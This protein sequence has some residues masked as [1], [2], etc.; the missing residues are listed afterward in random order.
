MA[1]IILLEGQHGI[2]LTR[3]PLA[4]SWD[5]VAY[6][7]LRASPPGAALEL[8]MSQQDDFH[9]FTMLYQLEAIR[10]RHP[11]VNGY[12]GWK[13]LLQEW[14][15]GP[16]SPL[17]DSGQTPD[18]LR[19]LRAIGVRA[20]LLHDATFPSAAEAERLANAVR[21]QRDQIVEEHRFGDTWAWRLRDADEGRRNA[22][23]ARI[24]PSG[25]DAFDQRSRAEFLVDGDADTR[26][27]SGR[28]QAGD[29]WIEI[30]LGQPA[31]VARVAI[32]TAA[33]SF[34]DYPRHLVVESDGRPLFDGSIVSKLV[35]AL[36]VD[37]RFPTVTLELPPN[38]THRLRIR[39]TAASDRWW[40]VH[41]VMLY[42]RQ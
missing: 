42:R 33:R 28:P 3:V 9:A 23:G 15:A 14:M 27:V 34:Y 38:Q 13:S 37:E 5:R 19:G 31:D 29:E 35:E 20:V 40:S 7:W 26:W 12:S 18:A 2:A 21:A 11:I 25:V 4:T 39:Q 10:H 6:D 24:P 41:D 30:A 8:N 17:K 16:D 22:D 36:A 32:V 1:G